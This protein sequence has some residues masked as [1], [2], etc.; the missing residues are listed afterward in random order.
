[1]M[2]ARVVKELWEKGDEVPE[3]LLT[4]LSPY[5][6]EHSNR[7]GEYR[8]DL[9]RLPPEPDYSFSCAP[10]DELLLQLSRQQGPVMPVG[11]GLSFI[12]VALL[13]RGIG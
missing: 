10:T 12:N 2:L 4:R 7:L 9:S 1:M 8:L 11:K 13:A 5:P 3:N 6:T